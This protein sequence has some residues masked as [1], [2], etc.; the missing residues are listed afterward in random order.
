MPDDHGENERAIRERAFFIWL[1]EGRPTGQADNHWMRA[2]LEEA[3]GKPGQ[4]ISL[5]YEERHETSRF[6]GNTPMTRKRRSPADQ[7]AAEGDK[8]RSEEALRRTEPEEQRASLK[9]FEIRQGL[10]INF[11]HVVSI[12]VLRRANGP[13]FAVLKLSN[14]ENQHITR[15]EFA[16]FVRGYPE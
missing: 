15:E 4:T 12:R 14:G 9:L 11:D 16:S 13:K 3:R 10:F 5:G 2:I 8:G 1:R 6:F 7:A